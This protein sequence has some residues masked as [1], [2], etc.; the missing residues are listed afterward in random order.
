MSR[1]INFCPPAIFDRKFRVVIRCSLCVC[2]SVCLCVTGMRGLES[3]RQ[4]FFIFCMKL[5]YDDT[6]KIHISNFPKIQHGPRYNDNQR[7]FAAKIQKSIR[8]SES[9]G[10]I[11]FIFYMKLAFNGVTKTHISIFQKIQ[12][13]THSQTTKTL[14]LN[15]PQI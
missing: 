10:Q 5:T 2:A 3:I 1:K 6:R 9:I 11:F 15:L 14:I 4:I 12:H 13:G 8:G 7:Q